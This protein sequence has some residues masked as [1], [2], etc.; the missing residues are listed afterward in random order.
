MHSASR[1]G[2]LLV[3][4]V[5]VV[6]LVGFITGIAIFFAQELGPVDEVPITIT[7]TVD[8]T[9]GEKSG[10]YSTDTRYVTLVYGVT[11]DGREFSKESYEIAVVVAGRKPIVGTATV[12]RLTGAVLDI[13]VNG[14]TTAAP[15]PPTWKAYLFASILATLVILFFG[16]VTFRNLR[17]A[18]PLSA[19]MKLAMLASAFVTGFVVWTVATA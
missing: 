15:E 4:F 1:F 10:K 13:T 17:A 9:V 18:L 19:F 5:S 2:Q 6:L 16:F 11:E 3:V 14:V 12:S 8:T 7:S